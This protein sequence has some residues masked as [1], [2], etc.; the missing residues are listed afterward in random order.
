MLAIFL[1]RAMMFRVFRRLALARNG[2]SRV[3]IA[4]SGDLAAMTAANLAKYG[5]FGLEVSGFLA[6]ATPSRGPSA[7]GRASWAAT[8]TWSGW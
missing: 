8:T 3:L 4:G 2:V 5:H 1:C 6:P 7:L